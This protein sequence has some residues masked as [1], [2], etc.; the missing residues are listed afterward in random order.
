MSATLIQYVYYY[1]PDI[2]N[3]W[4]NI[5]ALNTDG[6]TGMIEVQMIKTIDIGSI[7]IG[8]NGFYTFFITPEAFTS[9]YK[10]NYT[11]IINSNY[12]SAKMLT[13]I[14][15]NLTQPVIEYGINYANFNAWATYLLAKQGY[16]WLPYDSTYSGTIGSAAI[17][18]TKEGLTSANLYM[19][20]YTPV[21]SYTLPIK[22]PNSSA[23]T[24]TNISPTVTEVTSAQQSDQTATTTQSTTE[25]NNANVF[26]NL[27]KSISTAL[28]NAATD[29]SSPKAII[30]LG[31]AAAAII[32][33]AVIAVKK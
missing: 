19:L 16:Y 30:M 20:I 27:S 8:N 22:T 29:I 14:Y 21:A 11:S 33:I 31:L 1:P 18:P 3:T 6:T 25:I 13:N 4:R 12:S 7:D 32:G 5:T 15:N 24:I 9:W 26:N 23:T 17:D 2:M 10:N 28:N